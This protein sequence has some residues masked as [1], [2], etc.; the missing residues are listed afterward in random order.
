MFFRAHSLEQ[1]FT[2]V[3]AMFMMGG[4]NGRWVEWRQVLKVM[5]LMCVCRY[6]PEPITFLNLNKSKR[7]MFFLKFKRKV[8][9]EVSG[10]YCTIGKT[11]L[12]L[13]CLLIA[14]YRMNTAP[15]EFLYFQ[16]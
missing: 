15:M 8:M 11:V 7:V 4:E 13:I 16:F 14:L 10:A 2:I 1:A 3:G 12:A 6:L 5:A 9:W